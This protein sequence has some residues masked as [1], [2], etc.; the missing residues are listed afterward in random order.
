LADKRILVTG[1]GTFLGDS[2]AA[3]LLAEGAE[4]SLLVRPGAEDKL[5]PL[6]QRTRWWVADVW[7][8][9][10]MRGRARGH[11]SVVHTVG[12]VTADPRIG[13][14]YQWLNFV[15]ARNVANMCV[16][17]GCPHMVLMSAVRAPWVSRQYVNAKREAEAYMARVG[18][19]Y[20]IIRAPV[21]YLRGAPRHPFY[22]LMTALGSVPPTSWF[23]FGRVA[24]MPVD[25][26]A[27]GVARITLAPRRSR[28]I[29]YARDLRRLNTPQEARRPVPSPVNEDGARPRPLHPFELLD[30]N[31]PFGW[32]PPAD[33]PTRPRQ[34]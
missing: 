18:L 4:V 34:P 3:A 13:L 20:T 5:G 25:M 31:T 22:M 24:P 12:S 27:R 8:P 19:K 26:I 30:E 9:A 15:S 16:S 1:G 23:W 6:A 32:T 29:Y 2:I 17:D 28:T 21:G 10:S 33:D 7:N 11:A 14:T